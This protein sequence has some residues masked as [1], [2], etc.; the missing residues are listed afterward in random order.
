MQ[1]KKVLKIFGLSAAALLTLAACGTTTAKPSTYSDELI[2]T[3]SYSEQIYNNTARV[4]YDAVQKAGIGGDVLNEVLYLYAVTTFGPYNNTVNA[5]GV[6][7][8]LGEV[9]LSQAADSDANLSTFIK[10]HKVYWDESRAD[11]T[12]PV[13]ESEKERVKAK[14]QTVNDRIAERMY[15]KISGGA[16]SDRHI[17]SE[18]KFLK[19]LRKGLESVRDPEVG[20]ENLYEGQILPSVEPKDVFGANGYLHL[21]NYM[22]EANTY[23]V[24][25]IIPEIYRELLNEL[26]VTQET[27]STLGRSYAR[28]VNII[29]IKNNSNFPSASFYLANALV[30]ELNDPTSTID[31]VA[32]KFKDYSV[33]FLGTNATSSTTQEILD[34]AGGFKKVTDGSAFVG[35]YYEGTE[36]G[37]LATKFD[38]MINAKKIDTAAESS[39]SNSGA[40]PVYVG[41]QQKKMELEEKDYVTSGWFIKNGGLST[42]PDAIRNRLFNIAVANGV[43]E[44]DEDIEKTARKYDSVKKAWVEGET[45]GDY[46]CRINGHNYLKK[47]DRIKGES[48]E[49]DILHY[50][51]TSKSYYIIEIEEAVASSKLNLDSLT[52][53]AR[54]RGD[55][56]MESITN[57]V[58]Q[59]VAKSE[60][61]STLATKKYLKAMEFIYHDDSVY[62]YFYSN[63]PELFE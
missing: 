46:V 15:D 13:T 43:K 11:E 39:F 38:K 29:E 7:V 10:A 16:Y 41:L 14:I 55:S 52:N 32:Q 57:S 22:D 51:A 50:D 49:K 5:A 36:Y 27:Y 21:S 63:Y 34:K 30:K 2:K 20:T 9:T 47:A 17:F 3:A 35:T 6:P 19:E 26:Y 33:A 1:N 45:E 23:I 58:N 54:L 59:L 56:V 4:V 48:I 42:L 12:A 60:S 53:Y 18:K 44:K 25:K 8:G 24:D 28:K 62:N 61:Y 37:D 31:D 40:Y